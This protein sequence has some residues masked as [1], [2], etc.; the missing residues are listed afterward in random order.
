MWQRWESK[1]KKKS[2]AA[3]LEFASSSDCTGKIVAV[4]EQAP[5]GCIS[6]LQPPVYTPTGF[7]LRIG[8]P[9]RNPHLRRGPRRQLYCHQREDTGR[10][11][12]GQTQRKWAHP[13]GPPQPEMGASPSPARFLLCFFPRA[14]DWMLCPPK[15]HV[16]VLIN[17]NVMVFGRGDLRK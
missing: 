10:H 14:T 1:T 17:P 8:S 13:W 3:A 6:Y 2:V 12:R 5:Y 15:T 11:L 16:E 7:H 4:T 9:L